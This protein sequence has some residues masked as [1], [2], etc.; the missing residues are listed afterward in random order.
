MHQSEEYISK[1]THAHTLT[2]V[3]VCMW[4]CVTVFVKEIARERVRTK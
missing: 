4:M 1:Y 2:H 3:H